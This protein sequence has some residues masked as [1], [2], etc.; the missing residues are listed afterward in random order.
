MWSL[1]LALKPEM[2]TFHLR[3]TRSQPQDGES[4]YTMLVS[5]MQETENVCNIQIIPDEALTA[6]AITHLTPAEFEQDLQEAGKFNK[7]NTDLMRQHLVTQ[8]SESQ[9]AHSQKDAQKLEASGIGN[10]ISECKERNTVQSEITR[11][12]FTGPKSRVKPPYLLTSANGQ[13]ILDSIN[14]GVAQEFQIE[15]HE[16]LT[17]VYGSPSTKRLIKVQRYWLKK[18]QRVLLSN[19]TGF[20]SDDYTLPENTQPHQP[21]TPLNI[22]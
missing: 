10:T 11:P 20:S 4:R 22:E 7:R 13:E 12:S 5:D 1:F 2:I 21:T 16:S 9:Q 8:R 18:Y 17:S 19:L 3:K 15:T 14:L 6:N